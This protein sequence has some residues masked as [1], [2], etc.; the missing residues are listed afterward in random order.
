LVDLQEQDN[1]NR[2]LSDW[3]ENLIQHRHS[4]IWYEDPNA[5]IELFAKLD[6]YQFKYSEESDDELV[7][8]EYDSTEDDTTSEIDEV[9]E[10]ISG[11]IKSQ[12]ELN[13]K[14]QEQE[15][16]INRK[17]D[18]IISPKQEVK[19]PDIVEYKEPLDWKEHINDDIPDFNIGFVQLVQAHV[20]V[21]VEQRD[22]D[23]INKNKQGMIFTPRKD[24][25][26]KKQGFRI[27]RVG[28]IFF[29]GRSD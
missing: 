27:S 10:V 7:E 13:R 16:I 11:L 18:V 9:N 23:Y 1:Q 2:L 26:V 3:L 19:E 17:Q 22:I 4:F 24:A 29:E 15:K 28:K 20:K 21:G 25:K 12:G 14:I 6:L 8:I 5:E